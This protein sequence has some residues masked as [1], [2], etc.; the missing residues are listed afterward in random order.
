M[1][2]LSWGGGV[3]ALHVR[4]LIPGSN[5]SSVFGVGIAFSVIAIVVMGLRIHCRLHII[6]CGLG[7]DDC[8][9][10]RHPSNACFWSSM[11]CL[12]ANPEVLDLMLI[13]VLTNIGLSVANMI[14]G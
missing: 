10:P 13:G 4:E 6:G 7:T 8:E 11:S 3:D 2:A 14:C 12:C 9:L 5:Q 1:S